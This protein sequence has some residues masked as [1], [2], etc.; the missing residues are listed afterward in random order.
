MLEFQLEPVPSA[1][2]TVSTHTVW[3]SSRQAD[4]YASRWRGT[5]SRGRGRI[6]QGIGEN[7]MT[8]D[9]SSFPASVVF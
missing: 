9:A 1:A 6:R 4:S 7:N 2:I 5:W 8:A 3:L